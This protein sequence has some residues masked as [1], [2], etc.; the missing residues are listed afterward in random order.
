[1]YMLVLRNPFGITV[2]NAFVYV[3]QHESPLWSICANNHTH[4]VPQQQTE[5]TNMAIETH[6]YN[7][8]PLYTIGTNTLSQDRDRCHFIHQQ[9]PSISKRSFE[10][11]PERTTNCCSSIACC[12][13]RRR[14]GVFFANNNCMTRRTIPRIENRLAHR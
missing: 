4:T 8:T 6:L 3:G 7:S 1:M 13:R 10:Q 11:T 9:D 2:W 12:C 5:G 14:R